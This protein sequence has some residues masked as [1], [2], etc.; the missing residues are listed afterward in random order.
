[1]SGTPYKLSYTPLEYIKIGRPVDRI[2]YISRVC[3]NKV[4]LDLGALDE[5]AFTKKRTHGSWLHEEIAKVALRVIGL[6]SS[7]VVPANGLVTAENAM[8]RRGNILDLDSLISQIDV[9][10]DIVVA[11]ELIEHLV[12]DR[13]WHAYLQWVTVTPAKAGVQSLPLA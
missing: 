8:I 5:N 4:V 7:D 1:M 2:A 3:M 13:K 10:P 9:S 11:G 6:D 12:S